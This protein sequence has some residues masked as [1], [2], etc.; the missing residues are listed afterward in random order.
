MAEAGR[1]FIV[2]IWDGS[3]RLKR[4]VDMIREDF[5]VD[6]EYWHARSDTV[7]LVFKCHARLNVKHN[8]EGLIL[9]ES[10]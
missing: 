7:V 3:G 10:D 2:R 5:D 8:Q 9:A 4:I 6:E 1:V